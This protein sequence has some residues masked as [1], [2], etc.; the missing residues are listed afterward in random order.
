MRSGELVSIGY[1]ETPFGRL[2]AVL[3]E[4]GLCKLSFQGEGED[5]CYAW[6]RR[7]A[8][9]AEPC[10]DH[11]RLAALGEQFA[12]Y[13]AGH[14]RQFDLPLDL[15]GSPFQLAVWHAVEAI[16]YGQVRTYAEVAASIGH[17]TAVRAVGAANGANPVPIIVPC[18]RLIGSDG[19]LRG[20]GGGLDLKERLLKLEGGDPAPVRR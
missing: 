19:R 2:G 14:L 11:A 17:P 4:H 15:R 18:H 10:E 3:S 13:A 12:A 7:W 9:G 6:V 20:Y 1:V 16:A 5:A 8:P